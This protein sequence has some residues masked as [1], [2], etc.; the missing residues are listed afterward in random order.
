MSDSPAAIIVGEVLW[1]CFSE[2]DGG[3]RI[4]G[5]A[6]LNVA[7]N[8][9]GLGMDPLFIS[10]VGDDELG[11]EIIQRMKS[12]GMETEG[13]AVLPGVDTGTVQVTLQDGEPHYDI[14]KGVAWDQIPTPTHA[15]S[16]LISDRM[17]AAHRANLPALMY[18]GSLAFRDERSRATLTKLR[19]KI[20]HDPIR[21]SAFFD[22]NLRA[23]H[24]T[25]SLLDE[26]RR[27]ASFIKL[28][29]DELG[30]LGSEA[31]GDP[32]ERTMAAGRAFEKDTNDV[33]LSG[34]LV[35]LGSDGA[36]CYT[37]GCS[38]PLR[39]R[40]PEPESMEDPVGA[41]DA[42]AAVVMHGILTGRPFTNS[43]HDAVAFASKVCSLQGATCD[44][45]HFYRL[46]S[47]S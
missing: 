40:S 46:P 33:T 39:V 8:L 15:L 45:P 38:E 29:L 41:G 47:D 34:L 3:K 18:H 42:F 16:E 5:G 20:L 2:Q 4:L 13:V 31:D 24:Y 19:D 43:L 30:E 21:A 27:S 28:N 12:F 11:H 6:P 37:P 7:W 26:L 44:D 22:V 10:A 25:S 14:V 9:A 1:D 35:T 17:A 36:L 32:V 23:P